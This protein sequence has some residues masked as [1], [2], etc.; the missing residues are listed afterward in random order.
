MKEFFT[1]ERLFNLI[2][3]VVTPCLAGIITERLVANGVTFADDNNVGTKWI[4]VSERLPEKEG[5]YFVHHKGGFVSE[6]YFYE[7][8]PEMFIPFSNEPVTHWM[9]LPE[10]PKEGE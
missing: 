9:P 1:R 2:K 7:E 5:Y 3:Q 10:P 8:A 4:P 6:R